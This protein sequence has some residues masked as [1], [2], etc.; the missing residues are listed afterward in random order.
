MKKMQKLNLTCVIILL[1]S[2]ILPSFLP[3]RNIGLSALQATVVN[4]DSG[5]DVIALTEDEKEIIEEYDENEIIDVSNMTAEQEKVF[6][7]M[8][9]QSVESM[10]L[11]TTEDEASTVNEILNFFNSESDS[12]GDYEATT[13]NI[14]TEIDNNHETIFDNVFDDIS[15]EEVVAARKIVSVKVLGTILNVAISFVTGGAISWFIRKY[16]WSVLVTQIG[17]RVS[18]AFQIKRFSYLA[19]GLSKSAV[20]IANP[21]LTIAKLIDKNDKVRNNGWIDF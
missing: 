6:I 21:G 18:A 4:A 13:E 12:F 11:P 10:D 2:G 5:T 8:I 9:E 7:S 14:I 20:A 16:G 19:K 1:F 3:K 15:G 17:S